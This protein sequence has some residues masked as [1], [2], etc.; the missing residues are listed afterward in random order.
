MESIFE[1][2]FFSPNVLLLIFLFTDKTPAGVNFGLQSR[3]L[4]SV[5]WIGVLVMGEAGSTHYR[6]GH[7][8]TQLS[9]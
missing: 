3:G 4:Q 6:K 1:L 5:M 9:S 2:L 7:G 8:S